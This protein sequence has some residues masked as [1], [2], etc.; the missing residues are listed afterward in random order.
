MYIFY[1]LEAALRIKTHGIFQRYGMNT[2]EWIKELNEFVGAA[3]IFK[4]LTGMIANRFTSA[5]TNA[6]NFRG[7]T[8]ASSKTDSDVLTNRPQP[9]PEDP[10]EAA[11]KMSMYGPITRSV[12]EFFP[13]RLLCKRFDVKPPIHVQPIGANS[14]KSTGS[15]EPTHGPS[16]ELVSRAQMTEIMREARGDQNYILPEV[17]NIMSPVDTGTNEALE[18][19]RAGEDVFKAIFGDGGDDD[20]DG[21]D[22]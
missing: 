1:G 18:A 9:K 16:R 11:A 17:K 20:D 7:D 3:R 2:Q 22:D 15:W 8:D 21:M 4:P 13:T 14:E 6:S 19:E 12:V 5:T 10:A